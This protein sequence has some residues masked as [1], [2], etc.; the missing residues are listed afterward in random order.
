MG[1]RRQGAIFR[2]LLRALSCKRWLP[3]WLLSLLSLSFLRDLRI[4]S[5]MKK[6]FADSSIERPLLTITV[7]LSLRSISGQERFGYGLDGALKTWECV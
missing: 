1:S 2:V 3:L 7:T 4:D 5:G 6:T